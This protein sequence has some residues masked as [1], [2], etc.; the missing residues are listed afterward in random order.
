MPLT[1][2]GLSLPAALSARADMTFPRALKLWLIAHP[3]FKRSPVAPVEPALSLPA[4]ST[5][6]I[7]ED[8]CETGSPV[9]AAKSNTLWR[10]QSLCCDSVRFHITCGEYYFMEHMLNFVL[11]ALL[12]RHHIF[13]SWRA[14]LKL[15]FSMENE[16]PFIV[17]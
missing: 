11:S 4:R 13:S 6:L 14:V 1:C 17:S 2:P 16:M 7:S 9:P 3:S 10:A 8:F 12:C 15:K 5:K